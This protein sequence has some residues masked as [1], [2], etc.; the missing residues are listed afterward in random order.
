MIETYIYRK[1]GLILNNS[2]SSKRMLH[3]D[4]IIKNLGIDSSAKRQQIMIN[5]P[6]YYTG[7]AIH[8][9]HSNGGIVNNSASTMYDGVSSF[10]SLVKGFISF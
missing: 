8:N 10:L 3:Y 4:A 5:M 6:S 2:L 9:M 1:T 7:K